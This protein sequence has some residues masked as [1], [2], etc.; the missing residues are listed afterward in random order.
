MEWSW[1]LLILLITDVYN[2]GLK[3]YVMLCAIWLHLYNIR[4]V[5]NTHGR[6]LHLVKLQTSASNFTKN[7]NPPWVLIT[8][9]NNTNGTKIQRRLI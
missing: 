2:H 4:N 7:N 6:V 1:N 9:F 8:F 3:T 5:W